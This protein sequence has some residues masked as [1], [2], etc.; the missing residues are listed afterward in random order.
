MGKLSSSAV[1]FRIIKIDECVF[2]QAKTMYILYTNDYI[3][4]GPYEVKLR[5]IVV[6]IK[7]VG[8]DITEEGDL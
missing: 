5:H 6:D 2:Y 8:L 7:A 4:A 3:L 1:E